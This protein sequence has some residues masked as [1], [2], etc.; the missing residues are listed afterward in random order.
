MNCLM[1][2]VLEII[3][4]AQIA[5][6]IQIPTIDNVQKAIYNSLEHYCSVQKFKKEI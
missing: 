1:K 6:M 2:K 4:I 3:A 5:Q